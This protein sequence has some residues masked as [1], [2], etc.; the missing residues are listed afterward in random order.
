MKRLGYDSTEQVPARLAA[1]GSI[2]GCEQVGCFAILPQWLSMG[3][4]APAITVSQV[5]AL[6]YQAAQLTVQRSRPGR[7]IA[8]SLN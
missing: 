5:Y 8:P 7:Y 2:A 6:A 4:A 1:M 3:T